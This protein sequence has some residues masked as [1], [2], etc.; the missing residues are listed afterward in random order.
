MPGHDP[1]RYQA[2]TAGDAGVIN[3]EYHAFLA[4]K[5]AIA[6]L[7]GL[8]TIPRLSS[9]LFDFQKSAVDHNLACGSAGLF[10]DTG[11][12]KTLCQ[13]EYCEHARQAENGRALI[14][15]PLSVTQQIHREGM[16][17]GYQTRV[18]RDQSEA[19]EGINIANYDRLHLIDPAKF[20]VVSLD[21]SSI[22]KSFTGKT[23]RT[24]IDAFQDH[25]WRL[26]ATATPAPNDHMELGQHAEF[27]GIMQAN[28]MLSRFFINDT[29]TASQQWR[30]KG[31]ATVPFW[32]WMASWSRMAQLPSDLGGKD[33]GFVL[34]PINIERHRAAE[35]APRPTGG[36]FGDEHVSATNLHDIKR[37][38]IANRAKIAAELV[39]SDSKPWVIWCDTDYEADAIRDVLQG[40]DNVA[41]V[42]GSMTPDNK[43]DAIIGFSEGRVR[44][45]IT[46]PSICGF[47]LNW[48]HCANTVFVGRSFSYESWYQA[49][50]R[51]WRFGQQE[52]VNVHLIVAEGEDSIARVIDR[53]ADDHVDMKSAMR[54]A[55]LRNNSIGTAS[56]TAYLPTKKGSL[57]SWLNV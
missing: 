51:F 56:K 5:A 12:G 57:P 29:A 2:G 37:N 15:T 43:E 14:L 41:E 8:K 38:T 25:R 1:E 46:K 17:F 19:G 33:D 42:R 13:L 45:L 40:V 21:E 53:K 52:T 10:L 16:K 54:A 49:V 26:S 47:G 55:M 32:D 44:V 23:T 36:L 22:L 28:E 24:L 39:A 11:L 6:E 7:R 4:G 3:G 18:I 9:H 35:S 50:R 30:L 20:A 48:Q 31:Y 27:C 34:P